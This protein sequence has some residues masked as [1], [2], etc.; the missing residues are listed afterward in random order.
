[1]TPIQT[2]ATATCVAVTFA[3]FVASTLAAAPP[4]TAALRLACENTDGKTLAA[5]RIAA[6]S[7]MLATKEGDARSQALVYVNRAWAYGLEKQWDLAMA[8]YAAA[9]R[10]A[11]D[12]ALVY[13]EKGL[14]R[15]K[16][17]RLDEALINYDKALKLDPK[18]AFSL[19]GR[20]LVQSAK[21]NRPA[22]QADFA[23]ARA[24]SADIDAVFERIGLKP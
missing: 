17:G 8:D 11:P 15:L 23:A 10:L 21:G 18:S 7:G 14:A 3:A 24:L 2:F 5:G 9:V 1:M 12:Y 22:A 4:D 19:F 16:M 13:N 6:C 20:G